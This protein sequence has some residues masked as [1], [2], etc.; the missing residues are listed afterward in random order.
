MSQMRMKLNMSNSLGEDPI[1]SNE[2]NGDEVEHEHF[3]F[4]H[5]DEIPFSKLLFDLMVW[6]VQGS[7]NHY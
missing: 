3:E 4:P 5:D 6:Q 7:D 1:M 2:P